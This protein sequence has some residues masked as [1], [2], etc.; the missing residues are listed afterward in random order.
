MGLRASRA[1]C[2]KSRTKDTP[3]WYRLPSL[4]ERTSDGGMGNAEFGM[5]DALGTARLLLPAPRNN[6]M[7]SLR[8]QGRQSGEAARGVGM[9]GVAR[10][11]ADS[12]GSA[13][14]RAV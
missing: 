14:R 13:R 12:A 2:T 9:V 6:R 8:E 5:V 7:A 11:V 10:R 1:S 3:V 4:A